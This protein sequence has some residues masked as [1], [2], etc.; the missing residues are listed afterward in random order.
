MMMQSE[1]QTIAR[2]RNAAATRDVILAAARSRFLKESYDSVGLRDIAGDAGVDVALIGRYFGSK[3]K[4]FEAVLDTD[5][6]VEWPA[7]IAPGD[8]PAF[9]TTLFQAHDDAEHREHAEH[10]LII[11]RSASSPV[12]AGIARDA[13]RK[14]ILQPIADRLHGGAAEARASLAIAVWMGMT[15]LRSIMAV[16]PMC[17]AKCSLVSSKLASLY[18]A[19][20]SEMPS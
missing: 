14:D 8:I 5:G 13:M 9:L 17:D 12:A 3:E 16:E 2:P 19:A 4:L 20:L 6:C 10:L 15:V 11:L 18:D 1:C 7:E